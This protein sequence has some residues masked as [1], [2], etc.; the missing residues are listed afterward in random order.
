M[1]ELSNSTLVRDLLM[2]LDINPVTVIVSRNSELILE[3]E[4]LNNNDE[5]KILSVI[6]GG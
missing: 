3:D 5:I 2:K 4:Q 1:I 6:S